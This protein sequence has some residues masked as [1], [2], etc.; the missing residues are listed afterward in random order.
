M[1]MIVIADSPASWTGTVEEKMGN[2]LWP[3]WNALDFS[4]DFLFKG[5]LDKHEH[6]CM[7]LQ[8][9]HAGEDIFHGSR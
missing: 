2:F 6:I 5:R 1:L 4:T 3:L 8:F 7:Q 9:G